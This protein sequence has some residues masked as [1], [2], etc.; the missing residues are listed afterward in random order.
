MTAQNS[1][2]HALLAAALLITPFTAHAQDDAKQDTKPDTKPDGITVKDYLGHER[3]LHDGDGDSWD[4]LWCAIFADLTHR[5]KS[6]DSDKDGLTD[7][8]EMIMWRD[9]FIAGPVPQEVTPEEIKEAEQAAATAKVRALDEAKRLWP[10]RYA[11]LAEH[12]QRTFK[13]DKDASDPDFIRNDNAAVRAKLAARRDQAAADRGK[14]EAELD[15]IAAKYGAKRFDKRG[16]IV[17]ESSQGPIFMAPQDALSSISIGADA[18]WPAGLYTWQSTSV[19]RNLTGLGIRSSIWEANASDNTAGIRTTHAEFNGNRA[20]QIDGGAASN[21]G[22]AV[23]S[24]IVGGG[25][26]D[27]ERGM[28]NFGKLLRGIA[29]QG[30]LDGYNLTN[31]IQETANTA[32]GGQ[33]FSNHSYGVNG[34]WTN[35]VVNGISWPFWDY[36][37]LTEDPRLGL[38][39]PANAS[40]TT[41]ADLDQFVAMAET[42]LPV[43]AAGNPTG[44]GPGNPIPPATTIS[45]RIPAPGGTVVS[46]VVR[47][48]INGDDGYDTVLSPATA[49]N[50]LTVG[51]ITDINSGSFAFSGFTGRGPTDDGR[52][53]PDLTAVGQRNTSFGVGNSLFAATKTGRANFF[54]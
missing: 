36:P 46:T 47:D 8:E 1:T 26:Q 54:L 44:N 33:N 45:H 7:Y 20:V 11:K 25:I 5:N 17:G 27:V 16:T 38:Y 19:A 42:H 35:I 32:L 29:Y 6:I 39:S 43:F 21:H 37:A 18:L 30:E 53:K 40:G 34:G 15:R 3:I 13:T 10:E 41:S 24:V 14:T 2:R 31:F 52:I 23:A 9:P 50:V 49:K 22:T 51:S 48:W 28:S 12:L 4:D